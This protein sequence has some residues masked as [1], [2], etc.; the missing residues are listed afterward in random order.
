M[1]FRT[2]LILSLII[3][4]GIYAQ[5]PQQ[6]PQTPPPQPPA[7]AGNGP[8]PGPAVKT[9][10]PGERTAG[11]PTQGAG[12]TVHGQRGG[13]DFLAIGPA[14]DP[15]GAARGQKIFVANC[16]FC[17]GSNAAGGNSGPNLVRSV[18]VLHDKGTGNEIKPVIQHGRPDKGMPAFNFGED[19]IKD[20]ATFLLQRNQ[21]AANRMEY[22]LQNVV[23]GDPKEGEAY[24]S[25]HCA[26]CHSGTGD[27][28]HIATKFQ[29]DALQGRFLYPRESRHFGQAGTPP[30]PRGE[31]TVT[32]TLAS[33]QSYSGVLEHIDDFS[34][35]ITDQAGEHRS[36][37]YEEEKGLK[38]DIHDPLKEHAEL[39]RQYSNA[40]M[41]NILAYLETFK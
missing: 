26:S 2:S 7:G 4:T 3:G 36:W 23:T 38:V 21:A 30:D 10:G 28:A 16:A 37:L 20:I 17:H 15:A 19:Q 22:K 40:D 13:G 41:H 8:R 1:I 5:T 31:K 12:Q 11:T 32:V 33:G 14:A 9:P 35:A 27:L 24:F 25:A 34:V 29:P 39:L 18:L 6:T